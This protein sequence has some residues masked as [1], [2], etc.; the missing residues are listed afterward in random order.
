MFHLD[1]RTLFP[2]SLFR[3][4]AHRRLVRRHFHL[5]LAAEVEILENRTLLSVTLGSAETFAVLGAS[6]V[7]STGGTVVRGNLGVSPGSAV[8]GSPT[9]TGGTIHSADAISSQAQADLATAYNVLVGETLTSDLS[10][11]DLGGLTLTPGVYHF[12][13]SAALG[14]I[15]TLDAQGNPNAEWDFQIGTTL[16]TASNS[17]VVMINGGNAGRVYWQVGSSAT[18]GTGTVFAGHILAQTSITLDHG[19]SVTG[20]ALAITGAVT[21]DDNAVSVADSMSATFSF[22]GEYGVTT[23]NVVTLASITQTSGVLTL[24]GS[25]TATA[26]ITNSTQ[27]LVNG[28]DTAAYG[29]SSITFSSG[30]FAGQVW[31][32]LDLPV[33]YTNQGGAAVHITQ[34]GTSLTFVDKLGATS[35]GHWIS[36]TQFI[37]DDWGNET[38][39]IGN[40]TISWSVGVVW[41]ENLVIT[42]TNNGSGTTAITATP[43][44]IYVTDY[45]NPGGLAVHL[46]QTGTNNVVII[47][48]TGHMALGSFINSTQF[49]SSYFPGQVATISGNGNMISWSGGIVWTQSVST[50]AITVTN[51][52]N[53]NGI[54]VHLI[55]NGTN[56][57]AFIDALGR[58]SLGSMLSPTTVQCD[59][60]AGVVG[61]LSPT[62]ISWSNAIVWTR[63]NVIPLLITLTDSNGAVSHAQL[64]SPNSL[65]GLDGAMQGLT[66]MRVNGELFWSNGAFWANFDMNSIN[67]LFEMGTGYP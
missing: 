51:Y 45:V 2:K 19:A 28:A 43:S 8:T 40:G 3:Q 13:S 63:T 62:S 5:P 39:T 34:N 46:V 65:V 11:Q 15:L 67:A 35:T 18:I 25:S 1:V 50:G 26:T 64:T 9:V 24:M 36:P 37:A 61:T 57:L 29:N 60:F 66:A 52:T 41:S 27:I 58:T 14:A 21:M 22:P 47:D 23:G 17:S 32:K 38:G 16:T 20:G 59:L 7:T 56:Q 4:R 44:P 31:T 53:N 6:T 55:Q 54:P 49:S 33:N 12:A 10:G 30:A 42:G 48:A